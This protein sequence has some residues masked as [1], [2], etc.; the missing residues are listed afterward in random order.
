M[1][2]CFQQRTLN[3]SHDLCRHQFG[4]QYERFDGNLSVQMLHLQQKEQKMIMKRSVVYEEYETGLTP[5]EASV[6]YPNN[7]LVC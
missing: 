1:A 6:E 4:P 2:R 7:T 5:S 3:L